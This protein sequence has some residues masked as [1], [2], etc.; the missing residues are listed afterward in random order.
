MLRSL[1]LTNFRA[2]GSRQEMEF[3]IPDGRSP[4]SGLTILVGPNN[5]GKTS[6]F[7]AL[8]LASHSECVIDREQL[9]SGRPFEIDVTL[10]D[11][12]VELRAGRGTSHYAIVYPNALSGAAVSFPPGVHLTPLGEQLIVVRSRRAW[13]GRNASNQSLDSVQYANAVLEAEPNSVD[14]DF[15]S[16]LKDIATTRRH[17]DLNAMIRAVLPRFGQWMLDR[18]YGFDVVLY[19]AAGVIHT[20]DDAGEGVGSV[21][22]ICA[23]L[24]DADSPNCLLIDEPELSLHPQAQRRLAELL[25]RSSA[26]KQIIISTHS[27]HFV[28]WKDLTN[29]AR[30]YRVSKPT[31]RE[32]VLRRASSA[33]IAA[34][35]KLETS[36]QQP[37][38]LDDLAKEVFFTEGVVFLEGQEDVGLL[39]REIARHDVPSEFD[40]FG[41]GAAGA[42]N[43]A[44]F[45]SLAREVGIKAA[46]VYDGDKVDESKAIE[47]EFPDVLVEVL[48]TPDIRDKHSRDPRTQRET[49][50]VQKEGLFDRA[51]KLKPAYTTYL[52]ELLDRL[53]E[54]FG[55]FVSF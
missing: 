44:K 15:V 42:G 54:H 35:A 33:N 39:R 16:R 4:G 31:L 10:D 49:D 53:N 47:M 27:P 23:A 32:A 51:G 22:R 20:A 28:R 50:I 38:T 40:L 12:R 3:A 6:V 30:I 11:A 9:R 26:T 1:A 25:S 29:G 14:H 2:F 37:Q 17:P 52:D 21:M 19:E 18:T 36:W 13:A 5:S 8:L 48:P 34:I 7:R 45:L 46:A 55:V 41:Y 24:L 43:I